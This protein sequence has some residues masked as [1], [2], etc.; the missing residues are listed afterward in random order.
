MEAYGGNNALETKG[1]SALLMGALRWL[2]SLAGDQA[3]AVGGTNTGVPCLLPQFQLSAP[4]LSA[5]HPP[6]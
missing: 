2:P 5:Q 1:N 6:N 4:L 3:G